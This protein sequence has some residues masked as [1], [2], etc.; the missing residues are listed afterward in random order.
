MT[1]VIMNERF[2]LNRDDTLLPVPQRAVEGVA[3]YSYIKGLYN[4]EFR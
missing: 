2:C 4:S 1:A 3:K